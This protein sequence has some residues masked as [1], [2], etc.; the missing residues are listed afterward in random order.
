M[1][2][3]YKC[4]EC[5][6]E[7]ESLRSDEEAWT[8]FDEMFSGFTKDDVVVLCHDCWTKLGV[9]TKEMADE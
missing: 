3:V 1:G 7:F 6:G 9:A 8:E 5:G 4:E 2:K